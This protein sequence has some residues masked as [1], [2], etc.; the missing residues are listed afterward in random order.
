MYVSTHPGPAASRRPPLTA[1]SSETR[2]R[3]NDSSVC[4][5]PSLLLPFAAFPHARPC[6]MIQSS[7][8]SF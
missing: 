5:P 4:P 7:L 8:A 1:T 3:A 2:L 6:T